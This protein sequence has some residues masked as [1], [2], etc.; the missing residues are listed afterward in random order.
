M[1][2]ALQVQGG[3]LPSLPPPPPS[4]LATALKKCTKISQVLE[5]LHDFKGAY[6]DLTENFGN[7]GLKVNVKVTWN[8]GVRFEVVRSFCLVWTKQNVANHLPIFWLLLGSR[9]T[10]LK[11]PPFLDSNRNGCGNSAVNWSIAYHY[12]LSTPQPDSSVKW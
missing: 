8:W 3:K 5:F 4:P 10:L 6:R 1:C 9:L 2:L 7:S 11:L 12:M